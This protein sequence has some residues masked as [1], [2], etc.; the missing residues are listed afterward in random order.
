MSGYKYII[1]QKGN[2]ELP[3]I[4]PA[5]CVHSL[6]FQAVQ[7][8]TMQEIKTMYPEATSKM[9]ADAAL[10]LKVVGAGSVTFDV[11][12]AGGFSETLDVKSREQDSSVIQS[13]PYTSGL[14]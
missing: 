13:F 1:V 6:M 10:S 14:I 11:G 9:Q 12:K 8:M 7:V 3:F 2:Q 5:Q 4:F